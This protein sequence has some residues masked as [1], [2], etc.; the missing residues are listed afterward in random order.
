MPA[1]IQAVGRTLFVENI[2]HAQINNGVVAINPAGYFPLHVTGHEADAAL[3]AMQAAGF[4]GDDTLLVNPRRLIMLEKS[5]DIAH[6]YLEGTT[7]VLVVPT[8]FLACLEAV[9]LE[10]PSVKE[11]PSLEEALIEEVSETGNSEPK[12]RRKKAA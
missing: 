2:T 5:S 9:H 3:E 11:A 1:T 12:P 8:G 4:I 10:A 6:L 7:R